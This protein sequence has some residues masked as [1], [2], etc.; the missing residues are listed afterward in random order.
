VV[1]RGRGGDK[2]IKKIAKIV[3]HHIEMDRP[4]YLFIFFFFNG[5]LFQSFILSYIITK[6]HQI[7]LAIKIWMSDAWPKN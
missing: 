1:A 3:T 5:V 2:T 4:Y 7:V 6:I